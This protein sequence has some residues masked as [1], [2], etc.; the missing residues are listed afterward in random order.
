MMCI[1]RSSAAQT[2]YVALQNDETILL[3]RRHKCRHWLRF[4]GIDLN[5]KRIFVILRRL[6]PASGAGFCMGGRRVHHVLRDGRALEGSAQG[7]IEGY[8]EEIVCWK[9]E[10]GHE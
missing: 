5:S 9:S 10:L 7:E 4:R 2:G 6:L 3:W 1:C 8:V